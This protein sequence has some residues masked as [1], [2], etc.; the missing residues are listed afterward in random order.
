MGP[1]TIGKS[2]HHGIHLNSVKNVVI[3]N[4]KV[5][6]FDVGGIQL[7]NF[8]NAVIENVEIGPSATTV[9]ANVFYANA[10]FLLQKIKKIATRNGTATI[11]FADRASPVTVTSIYNN[12]VKS[13]NLFFKYIF[14]DGD[15]NI[16]SLPVTRQN[17]EVVK[18]YNLFANKNKLPD[19]A[20]LY[21]ILLNSYGPAVF[22]F[23]DSPGNS[24]NAKITNVSIHDLKNNVREIIGYY[25]TANNNRIPIR[26]P[27]SDVL[28]MGSICLNSTSSL[29]TC[30]YKGTVLSD[31]QIAIALMGK[32]SF[33]ETGI[34]SSTTNFKNWAQN[35]AKLTT[36]NIRCG[37]DIMT[38][39]IKGIMGIRV[40][41]TIDVEINSTKISNLI[42]NSPLGSNL[43]GV[44]RTESDLASAYG[45]YD[46]YMG[47]HVKGIVTTNSDNVM[48]NNVELNSFQSLYGDVAGIDIREDST[49]VLNN[50]NNKISNLNAGSSLNSN[51]A[52]FLQSNPY[53][54][55]YPEICGLQYDETSSIALIGSSNPSDHVTI[56]NLNGYSPCDNEFEA[57]NVI[58]RRISIQI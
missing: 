45:I 9:H 35:D 50:N 56:S 28:D 8:Q 57:N 40:D 20:S 52:S 58:T 31:A 51:Q 42:S 54:N 37:A 29:S 32:S 33:D 16:N 13:M 17:T 11:K 26:G 24:S 3:K 44:Y 34:Q 39:T 30:T 12:L 21:G 18:A 41:N 55:H 49:V 48:L 5:S 7:N 27:F 22:A 6:D 23:G 1:G 43:C 4:L 25:S 36:G 2:S 14:V 10:R 47:T 38:H 15:P 53:P 19:G 46:G